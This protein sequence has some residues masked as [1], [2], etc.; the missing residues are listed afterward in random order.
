MQYE[1]ISN[2]RSTLG[3]GISIRPN[4]PEVSWVDIEGNKVF[5]KNLDSGKSGVLLDFEYPS[6]TFSDGDS[7]VFIS[8]LGGI[9]WVD[10]NY[11]NRQVCTTWFP[12]N[13]GLR[14][15]DGKMDRDGN[16]WISTMSISH[17]SNQ[18]SIWFWDRKSTPRLVLDNLT[19][20]NSIAVDEGRNRVYFADSAKN[21][22]YQGNASEIS[23]GINSIE[24][25]FFSK[26]GIPDG[27]T[28]DSY[29][30][31]WNTRWDGSSVFKIS[32]QGEVLEVLDTPFLRP[33]SCVFSHN[34]NEL[35][36]TSASVESD[37]KSGHTVRIA[38]GQVSG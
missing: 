3:E 24:T 35:L 27:S 8:H 2:T 37:L 25:F 15:N 36:V 29:G 20:P 26:D 22:I 17:L 6:C 14:C 7:G 5:W 1:I 19:I 38:I 32:W 13:S 4:K 21:T 23:P 18:G 12:N 33:T 16:I 10:M 11:Q 28:L 9:D 31:L 30:N 34:K